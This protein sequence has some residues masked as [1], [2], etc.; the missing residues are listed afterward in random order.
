[1]PTASAR[2]CGRV[3][4]DRLASRLDYVKGTF[5]QAAKYPDARTDECGGVPGAAPCPAPSRCGRRH[6]ARRAATT[7]E[8]GR[9]LSEG[10][11]CADHEVPAPRGSP[12]RQLLMRAMKSCFTACGPCDGRPWSRRHDGLSAARRGRAGARRSDHAAWRPR[13]DGA[14]GMAGC[15]ARHG[16][17]RALASASGCCRS[18]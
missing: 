2:C 14:A 4:R 16:A 10:S 7:A 17:A 1:M 6:N 3:G 5:P 11:A 12:M 9:N 18:T 15:R 8:C 13:H